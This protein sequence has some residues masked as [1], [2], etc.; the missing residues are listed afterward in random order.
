MNSISVYITGSI[1]A[2]LLV[3]SGKLNDNISF[4]EIEKE[5][6]AE[7]ADLMST[8]VSK[9]ELD[10]VKNQAESSH[11]FSEMELLN[12]A[13]S[14]AYFTM[15]GDTSLINNEVNKIRNVTVE[16]I[17]QMA[18]KILNKNNSSTLYYKKISKN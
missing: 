18:Q 10:K 3:I 13:F 5:I 8:L 1:D 7:I 15:L 12:K 17:Q 4:E 14:L 16:G 11:V 9:K 6:E 2:G